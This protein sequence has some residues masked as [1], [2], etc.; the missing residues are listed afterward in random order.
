MAAINQGPADQAE[1]AAASAL[2][3]AGLPATMSTPAGQGTIT[4]YQ[5][6]RINDLA[7]NQVASRNTGYAPAVQKKST[8]STSSSRGY[9]SGGGGGGGGGVPKFTQAQLDWAAQLMQGGRPG[10]LTANTLDLPDYQGMALRAF[11][12]SQW[13]T[14]RTALGEG[15]NQDI[16]TAQ[17]ATSNMLNYLNTNYRNPFAQGPQTTMAQAPGMDQQAMGRLM[18]GQGVNAYENPQYQQTLNEGRQSDAGLSSLFAALAGSEDV[19]QR[20]R[21]GNAQQ[22]GTQAT[23]AITAAKRAGD[24]GLNLG[25]GQAQSQWQTAADQRAYQDYQMQQQIAQQEAQS[26]WERQNQ[27]QD[28][29]STNTNSYN[30]SVLQS[31]LG[32]LPQLQSNPSLALP[33]LQSLGLA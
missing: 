31:L 11:D 19:M 5:V 17:G 3:A 26:N 27:V 21:V 2:R 14:A 10:A 8:G 30:N 4:Q 32:L 1:A 23:D 20:G 9:S 15:Y 12:P 18:Q 7:N 6:Q 16:G 33:T 13:N 22:Y 29:N 24:L 25:Q 28:T